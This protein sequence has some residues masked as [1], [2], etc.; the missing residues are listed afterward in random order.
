MLTYPWFGVSPR[1]WGWV[2]AVFV[3][4]VLDLWLG[5]V[6]AGLVRRRHAAALRRA[7]SALPRE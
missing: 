2:L 1:I 6:V 3:A 4:F 5:P 7:L